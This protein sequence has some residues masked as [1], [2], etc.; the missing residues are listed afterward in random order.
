MEVGNELFNK[1]YESLELLGVDLYSHLPNEVPYPFVSFGEM[2]VYEEETNKSVVSGR[3]GQT[4][5]IWDDDMKRVGSNRNLQGLVV[6]VCRGIV[7]TE[8][9]QFRIMP[10][11]VDRRMTEDTSTEKTLL[12]GLVYVEYKYFRKGN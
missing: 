3:V 4:F 10:R 12:H 7:E 2:T 5:H 6:A 9:F 1:M 11:G 8:N